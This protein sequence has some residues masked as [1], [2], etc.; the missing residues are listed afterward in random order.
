MIPIASTKDLP[1]EKWLEYRRL[2]IGGSDAS[3]VCGVNQYKSPIELW[4]DKTGQLPHTQAGEAAHWGRMLEPIVRAEFTRRTGIEVIKVN[5]ILQSEDYPFMIANLD[6]V[7]KHP[8]YGKCVFEAK[9][10][11]A[12]KAGEWEADAVPYEYVLQVQHYMAVTGYEGACVAV[13]IGGNRFQ[14]KYVPRDEEVITMLIRRE[15]D[16]WSH[17]QDGVPPDLDGSDSSAAYLNK[18]FPQGA[19]STKTDLPDSAVDLI[20]QYSEAGEQLERITEQKRK[21][22]NLLKQ[23]LGTNETGIAGN[24]FITWKNVSQERFDSKLFESEEPEIYKR[25]LRKTTHRRF[26]VK[27]VG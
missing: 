10:A 25:Y 8:Y 24:S 11:N 27:E 3:V 20:R 13:L 9:T 5:Q 16:F 22:A 21:A 19:A 23:M 18:R 7:C 2:G 1:Y 14:W 12:F 4:M 17:V 26:I 6:G 15:T